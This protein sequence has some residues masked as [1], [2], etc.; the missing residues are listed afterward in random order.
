MKDENEEFRSEAAARGPLGWI[1]GFA[2]AALLL[3]FVF[4]MANPIGG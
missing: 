3:W 4:A 1:L 2:M